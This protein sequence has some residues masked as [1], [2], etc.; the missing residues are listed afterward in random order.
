MNK[1]IEL[2]FNKFESSALCKNK[3]TGSA[4]FPCVISLAIIAGLGCPELL[5]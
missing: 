2:I 3:Y 1:V 4:W 5:R